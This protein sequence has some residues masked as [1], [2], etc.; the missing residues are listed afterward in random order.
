M[1]YSHCLSDHKQTKAKH[2]HYHLLLP[3]EKK[4][5]QWPLQN[6]YRKVPTFL[7]ILLP[8]PDHCTFQTGYGSR[9]VLEITP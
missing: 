3:R 7:S 5:T 9:A 1:Q 8:E 4:T 2:N 6:M